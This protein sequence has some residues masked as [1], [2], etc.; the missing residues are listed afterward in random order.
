MDEEAA[1]RGVFRNKYAAFLQDKLKAANIP[2]TWLLMSVTLDGYD[3][4]AAV[5]LADTFSKNGEKLFFLDE[6]LTPRVAIKGFFLWLRQIAV[7]FFL[8]Q[9]L[10]KDGL[11]AAPVGRRCGGVVKSLWNTS[12]FGPVAVNGILYALIFRE[13]FKRFRGVEDCLYLC[14]MHAW[15]MALNAAKKELSPRTRTIGHQHSSVSRN[16]LGYFH[17]RSETVRT[18]EPS[19]L[20]LPDVMACNGGHLY[21]LLSESGYPGLIE[22]EAVRYMYMDKVLSLPRA[23]HKGR[24]LLLVAGPYN[25]EEARS[26]VC[27]VAAAFPSGG[28]FDIWFK[29]HP[30]MPLENIFLEL[31]LDSAVT[32]FVIKH[33]NIAEYL[34]K[35]WAVLVPT[36]TV[37]IEALG[38]GCDVIIPVFPDAM[39]MN[40]LA[41]FDDHSHTVTNP[42]ELRAVMDKIAGGSSLRDIDYCRRFVRKYWNLDPALPLWSKLLAGGKR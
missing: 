25:R 34:N 26:L 24:P 42:Q 5:K 29:G 23:P 4:G 15:E 13:V 1:G 31:G 22:T 36:S 14:E 37:A 10:K 12:F 11:T 7:G 27:L 16:D 3:F 20:P 41:D 8:F 39:L 35:A 9:R 38:A 6:F 2:V 21:A 19:E 32:G 17:D 18:G 33:G 28:G 40:P 30:A